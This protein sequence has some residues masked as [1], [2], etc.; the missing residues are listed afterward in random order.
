MTIQTFLFSVVPYVAMGLL[1]VVTL[2]RW[3]RHP[4]SVSSLSSQLLES[5]RL[6][7]GSVS[8]HWGL[9]VVLVGHL[10][11][12]IVPRGIELW[13]GAPLRLYLLEATGLALGLWAAF[14]LIVLL[15]RRLGNPRIRAVTTPMD[16][17][18]LLLLAVQIG[19][20]IWMAIAYRWGSFWGTSVLVPYMRSVLTFS[21]DAS[22]LQ[23]LPFVV[24]LHVFAFWL[25][26]AIFAFSRLVHII[27]LPLGYVVH[28]WQRVI[29][30]R[31][32]PAVFHPAADTVLEKSV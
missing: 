30:N 6:Y 15:I 16:V 22:Y 1:V 18:V 28:P 10:A 3:R 27:T 26:V 25:F 14:G 11:A 4:F 9:T 23:P 21:P 2:W 20:G 5:R 24:Q 13:N 12:L 31:T 8:F 7:W 32:E 29:G 17:A 19:T